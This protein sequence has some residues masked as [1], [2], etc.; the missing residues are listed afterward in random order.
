MSLAEPPVPAPTWPA[1]NVR[2]GDHLE[3]VIT[4]DFFRD[5]VDAR[6]VTLAGREAQSLML[7]QSGPPLDPSMVDQE[8][9]LSL[10]AGQRRLGFTVRLMSLLDDGR[11]ILVSLPTGAGRELNLRLYHRVAVLPQDGL[12]LLLQPSPGP[13]RLLNLSLGGALVSV[14]GQPDWEQGQE[15]SFTLLARGGDRIGGLARLARLAPAP[16]PGHTLMALQFKGMP[17]AEARLLKRLV[18][19]LDRAS[20]PHVME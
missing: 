4:L 15:L 3:L 9:E 2:A 5:W 6:T 1:L 7:T 14:R 13:V 8:M 10:I 18:T 20:R 17:T 16:Q 19:R 11:R 12:L